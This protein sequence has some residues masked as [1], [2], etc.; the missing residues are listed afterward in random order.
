VSVA[1]L[2]A[3]TQLQALRDR[4]RF[5]ELVFRAEKLVALAVLPAAALLV[6][7]AEP[8]LSLWLGPEFAERSAWP[9]RLLVAGYALSALGTVPAVACDAVGRPGVT[10]AFSLAGAAFNVSLCVVLIPRFGITGAAAVIL[11]QSLVSLPIFLW[12]ASR[13]VLSLRVSDLLLRSLL[14]PAAAAVLASGAMLLVL[15]LVDGWG[16]LVAAIA[17][18][19]AVYGGA[20]KAVGAYDA[21]DRGAAVRS[22]RRPGPAVGVADAP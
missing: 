6:V 11:C 2:P 14:R 4:A 12:F 3:A 20:A 1:F 21:I 16:S 5:E 9:L 15:P 22:L 10:T 19:L 8:I 7:F 18:S 17:V 13:R